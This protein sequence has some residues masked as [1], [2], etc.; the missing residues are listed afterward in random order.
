M[1]LFDIVFHHEHQ[2][3]WKVQRFST[4]SAQSSRTK[5]ARALKKD[6]HGCSVFTLYALS[7]LG[8]FEK[9]QSKI[10]TLIVSNLISR[11]YSI[12]EGRTSN[13]FYVHL[14]ECPWVNIFIYSGLNFCFLYCCGVTAIKNRNSWQLKYVWCFSQRMA[15]CTFPKNSIL[16]SSHGLHWYLTCTVMY[17][18][19]YVFSDVRYCAWDPVERVMFSWSLLQLWKLWRVFRHY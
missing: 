10:F 13:L 3:F 4:K 11:P 18:S 15:F 7:S 2:P 5:K 1:S 17:F 16:W 14:S 8:T 19:T 9:T 6:V 12:V